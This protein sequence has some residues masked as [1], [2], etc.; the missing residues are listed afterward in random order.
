V[1]PSDAAKRTQE[2]LALHRAGRLAEAEPLYLKVLAAHKDFHPALHLL[3]LLR[4]HQGRAAEALTYIER[5]LALHPGTAEALLD[6]GVALDG[7]GRYG[8]ALRAVESVVKLSPDNS[9]AWTT[10]GA[11]LAKLHRNEEALADFNR[12]LTLDSANAAAWNNRGLTLVALERPEEALESYNRLLQLRPNDLQARNNR[13]LALKA[14]GRPADALSEFDRVLQEKPD[15]AGALVNRAGA[16]SSMGEVDQALQSYDRALAIQPNMP[17]ALVD[18]AFCLWTAKKDLAAAIADLQRALAARPDYPGARGDLLLMKL[19]AGDWR[20]LARERAALDEGVRAG[21][22]IVQPYVYQAISSSPAD[23]LACARIYARHNYPACSSAVRHGLR[24]GRIRVGYVSGEFRGQATMH[25]AAGLFELHDR[26]R[27]DVVGFDNTVEDG[28][29]LRRRVMAAFDRFLPIQGLSDRAAARLISDQQ[30]DI[31]V[32]LSGYMGTP[33]MGVFAHRPAPLQVNY[34][35]FPGTLGVEYLDYILADAEVIPEGEQRF[36]SEQVVRLPGCY[37]INDSARIRPGPS[38]RAAHGLKS[39]DFVFCNFNYPYKI[40]PEVFGIWLRLLKN[41]P[42]SVLWLLENNPL[43][44]ANLRREA[45]QADVDPTRLVFAPQLEI[46][47]HLA[48]L[49]LGDLFLDSLPCN[50]HTTASDALWV[51]L[52]LVTCRG[53]TFPGRVAASLLCAVGIPEL[54]TDSLD[55]YESLALKLANDRALLHSY[56]ERLTEDPA[57]L[58]LFDTARTTRHIEAA[59]EEMMARWSKGLPPAAFA[60]PA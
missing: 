35:G 46:S 14:L 36:Y 5:G 54:I 52:P 50:A 47:A 6:Y 16:L 8:D 18:R 4:L 20:D 12:A 22:R 49:Q 40:T 9:N 43:I 60:V 13:G 3:G 53:Q 51:G 38:S 7:V 21:R 55:E 34:L 11:L 59:Y 2:A 23:L 39:T 37:Q 19:H 10:R 57:R 25:L 1:T 48:R 28:S 17:E 42:A 56:R 32:N 31:L 24:Q 29:P 58:P 26:T 44:A 27:F 30:I 15:H 33:R 41:V 45:A